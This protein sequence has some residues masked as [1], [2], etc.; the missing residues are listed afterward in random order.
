[1][2]ATPS[3]PCCPIGARPDA[4]AIDAALGAG[5]ETLSAIATRFEVAKSSLHKHRTL[6]LH[7]HGTAVNAAERE[8]ERPAERQTKP[9]PS[10]NADGTRVNGVNTAGTRTSPFAVAAPGDDALTAPRKV[11]RAQ[12]EAQA[13]D[14]RA[15][16]KSL[17]RI[18]EELG[19]DEET[20]ADLVECALKRIR[21]GTD[22]KADKARA[23]ELHRLD[24]LL[25]TLWPRAT[26][27]KASG[28]PI[29]GGDGEIVGFGYSPAQDKAIER[30]TKLL[31]R[32]AKLMGLDAPTGPKTVINIGEDPRAKQWMVSVNAAL[33]AEGAA[34]G[35]PDL[36]IRVVARVR[37]AM[38]GG[39]P[40]GAQ[41]IDMT[42]RLQLA[43]KAPDGDRGPEGESA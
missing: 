3:P 38:A 16:G 18:G 34:L 12:L 28:E 42:P 33:D 40:T 35:I 9:S 5:T 37:E 7:A 25:G 15:A 29:V 39:K 8:P 23:L 43:P 30:I 10:V 21:K 11:V 2:G 36:K 6:H 41:V 19:V 32:R 20:A 31:E 13:V 14:L 4:A 26:D 22:A 27:P 17:A 1:M 24:L